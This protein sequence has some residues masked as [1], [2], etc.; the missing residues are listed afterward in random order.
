MSTAFGTRQ[1]LPNLIISLWL[2]GFTQIIGYGTLYYGLAIIAEDMA[3]T[4]GWPVSWIFGAFSLALLAGAVI[5]PA[6]GR[7]ID[8]HG[9]A[10]VMALGSVAAAV[11]LIITASAPNP[12]VFVIGLVAMQLASTLVLYDAA[13]AHLVEVSGPA[14]P[15]LITYLTLI[16]GFSSTIFWPLTQTLSEWFSWR[17]I[18]AI[19][20]AMNVAICFPVHLWL[21]RSGTGSL[22][23]LPL[24]TGVDLPTL[25]A[26][27]LPDHLERR[28]LFLVTWGFALSGFLLMAILAQ[29]VPLLSA[30]GLGS[31]SVMVA[32]LFGPAQVLIRFVNMVLGTER[33]PLAVTLLV[34]VLLPIAALLLAASA[35]WIFGA[36]IFALMLGFA[37]GLKSIVQGTLPLTLFGAAGYATRLGKMAAVRLVL[38]ALAPF[39]LAHLLEVLGPRL[40]LASL[41]LFGVAGLV[42][43]LEVARLR[44][45]TKHRGA[46]PTT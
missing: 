38:A 19:F 28:G 46:I 5:A 17:E 7:R 13:F 22:C 11:S 24:Q 36:V 6:V 3:T 10:K 37:S 20:A 1:T 9:A 35:P 30:I 4:L 34:A 2:L 25:D 40:A 27:P 42:A 26:S 39:V 32:A 8:Q 16:A 31:A 15:R 44:H 33:Y 14:S 29:M 18:L 41:A 12:L 45:R 23:N 21:A 43:F